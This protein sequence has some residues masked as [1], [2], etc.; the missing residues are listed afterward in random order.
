MKAKSSMYN[1]GVRGWLMIAYLFL[2]YFI[3]TTCIDS[4]NIAPMLWQATKGWDYTVLLG[5]GS[6]GGWV[7]VALALLCAFLARK[8]GVKIP[9]SVSLIIAGIFTGLT[10]YAVSEQQ[11]MICFVIQVGLANVIGLTFPNIFASNWWPTKKGIALGIATIGMCLSGAITTLIFQNVF[12]A[13]GSLVVCYWIFG[14]IFI[15]TGIITIFVHDYPEK[16]GMFPDNLSEQDARVQ[17]EQFSKIKDY[18]SPW[19]A[20]KLL[21]NGQFW[22]IILVF[23]MQ[24]LVLLFSM[25]QFLPRY[26]SATDAAGN[27]LFE[28]GTILTMLVVTNVVGMFGSYLSGILDQKLG[29]K[30]TTVILCI[31]NLLLQLAGLVFWSSRVGSLIIMACLGLMVGS[32]GNLFVSY[33]IMLWGR[34]DF[35]SA[36]V[37]I[38][39]IVSVIR[40]SVFIIQSSILSANGYSYKG[41]LMVFAGIA[42]VSLILSFF[43]RKEPFNQAE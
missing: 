36:N 28:Q 17:A 26:L 20:G 39:P 18:K 5:Y 3:S 4:M 30:K 24:F 10:G 40:A 2:L 41:L 13:T 22:L 15:I 32:V 8:I 6:I 7:S 21:S 25:S 38:V 29:T 16:C 42:A 31:I 9:T 23:G 37:W 43:L 12:A 11:Y 33:P 34:L 14:A 35:P 27:P 1:L 19:T